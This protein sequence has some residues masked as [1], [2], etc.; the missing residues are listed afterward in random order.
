MGPTGW[1]FSLVISWGTFP[2]PALRLRLRLHAAPEPLYDQLP[3]ANGSALRSNFS[4]SF[5]PSFLVFFF[6]LSSLDDER[7]RI[8]AQVAPHTP[9]DFCSCSLFRVKNRAE[10]ELHDIY[11]GDGEAE[12]HRPR[13][14]RHPGRLLGGEGRTSCPPPCFSSAASLQHQPP[15]RRLQQPFPEPARHY[16]REAEHIGR[17]HACLLPHPP[18]GRRLLPLRLRL[19]CR[20]R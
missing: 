17:L 15:P 9:I 6:Y 13:G 14:D 1:L 16:R 8:R 4:S 12:C 7:S 10:T 11:R 3:D 5:L 19:V 2:R 20:R 18:Q